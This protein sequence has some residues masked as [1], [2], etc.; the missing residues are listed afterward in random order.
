MTTISQTAFARRSKS[1][2]RAAGYVGASILTIAWAFHAYWAAGGEWGAA[3][4]YGS[5]DLPPQAATALVTVLIAGA[6]LFLLARVGGIPAPLPRWM[7]RIGPWMLAATFALAGVTNLIQPKDAYARDW[8][9][10]FF[11]P[12]LVTLAALC[13]TSA[14]AALP[15]ASEEARAPRRA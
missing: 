4:A 14:T 10:Y 1:I 8:H 15:G 13:A 5:T 11:G 3:T 12:L 2:P 9:I 7:L 6:G